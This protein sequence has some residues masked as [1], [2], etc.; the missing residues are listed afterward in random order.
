MDNL[1]SSL[2]M[3]REVSFLENVL[4]RSEFRQIVKHSSTIFYGLIL[5]ALLL[6]FFYRN[7]L[8]EKAKAESDYF[9][10]E[11]DF[12]T[13]NEIPVTEEERIS[14]EEA[15]IDLKNILAVRPELHGKYDAGLTEALIIKNRP[16][17]ALSFAKGAIARTEKN[18]LHDYTEFAKITLAI[19]S[20]D[21]P[22][23]L[24]K[25]L[26]LKQTIEKSENSSGK[27]YAYNLLRIVTLMEETGNPEIESARKELFDFFYGDASPDHPIATPETRTAFENLFAEGNITFK[28]YLD[29]QKN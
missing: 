17:E 21:L 13:F 12:R 8:E 11:K 15:F 16:E 25:S 4:N 5:A 6:L 26:L 9:T 24:Q 2:K 3:Y 14:E 22:G 28:S 7:G 10:A 27:L 29:R 20:G 18:G 19:T 1:D 23:A